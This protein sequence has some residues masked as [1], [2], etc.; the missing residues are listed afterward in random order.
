M[1]I[2]SLDYSILITYQ[3]DILAVKFDILFNKF[4]SL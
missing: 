3:K 1:K 4:I 2:P